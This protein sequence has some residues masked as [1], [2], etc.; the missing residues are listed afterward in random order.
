M[1]FSYRDDKNHTVSFV[2]ALFANYKRRKNPL[3]LEF[4]ILSSLLVFTLNFSIIFILTL[5]VL[6]VIFRAAKIC[7]CRQ[8]PV[9]ILS[10]Y[11]NVI[12]LNLIFDDD[13]EDECLDSSLDYCL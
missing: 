10:Q 2:I 6:I 7:R 11:E 5:W 12:I 3:M 1:K 8:S 4:S 13:S 9:C